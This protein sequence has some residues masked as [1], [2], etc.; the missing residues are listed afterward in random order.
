MR[1]GGAAVTARLALLVAAM[2]AGGARV[3][4][5]DLLGAHRAL[6]AVDASSR[7]DAYLALRAALC[8]R[9]ADLEV[10][11]AAFEVVLGRAEGRGQRAGGEVPEAAGLARPLMAVPPMAE[12]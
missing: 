10:F 11:D 9:Q 12:P 5:G 2:R 3:G 1:S 8:S 7:G 4:V 6:A